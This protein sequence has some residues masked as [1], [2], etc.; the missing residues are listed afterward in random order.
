LIGAKELATMKPTARIINTSRG[1]LV[2]EEALAM[3][4]KEKK[5]AGAAVDVF[6]V[7]PATSSPLFECENVL[8][9]PHLGAST[10]EAQ[11]MAA[12]DVAIQVVDVLSGRSPRW[13]VNAFFI[14]PESA[15]VLKPFMDLASA[16]GKVLY[17]LGEGQM[18]S[19]QI[20]YE[21]EITNY[22][23]NALKAAFLGGF[24]ENVSEERVNLVNA[25]LIATRRKIS[26]VE[27][28][29]SSCQNYSSLMT[30]EVTTTTGPY[31][32]AG[33]IMRGESH[34]V[35]VNNFWIDFVPTP[36]LFLFIAHKDRPGLIGAVGDVTGKSDV[37][38]RSMH[39]SRL[40]PRGEALMILDL[41]EP[42]PQEGIK[43][44]LA[45]P[46]VY[47]AKTVTI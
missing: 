2:N 45:I 33:T 47:T 46:D 6:P 29:D 22:D 31:T 37:N 20:K 23:T 34:I 4:A 21:G 30:A 5:I 15:A 10:A 43:K 16:M 39:V 35:R 14:S 8:V 1:G 11:A 25:N 18:K 7:E 38:I 19:I 42:L 28:K 26:V 12:T 9:T 44:L 40:K 27:Q 17:K 36:G 24:L 32:V 41:D 13:A 3:A